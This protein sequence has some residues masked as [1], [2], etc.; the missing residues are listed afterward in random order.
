M[1]YLFTYQYIFIYLTNKYIALT[2]NSQPLTH[3]SLMMILWVCTIVFPF[4][5]WGKWGT[6]RLRNM[7]NM[8]QSQDSNPGILTGA[9]SARRPLPVWAWVMLCEPCSQSTWG[10]SKCTWN[11]LPALQCVPMP[12][13]TLISLLSSK[14]IF[15]VHP[16]CGPAFTNGCVPWPPDFWT[17]F[18]LFLSLNC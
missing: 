9:G 18:C 1:I 6:K 13:A 12:G 3:L 17:T 11:Q 7:L 14:S 5:R 16:P 10:H 2:R 8:W 4:Y 15:L